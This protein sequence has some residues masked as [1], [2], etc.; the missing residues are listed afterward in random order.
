[1]NSLSKELQDS[2]TELLAD[3]KKAV[4]YNPRWWLTALKMIR[5]QRQAIQQRK[6]HLEVHGMHIPPMLIVSVTNRCNLTCKGCYNQKFHAST[7]Q[8]MSD[9]RL[10]A[11][12]QEAEVLGI[13]YVILVGG[14]PLSRPGLLNILS[15]FSKID[16]I[17]FTNGTLINAETVQIFRKQ[18]HIIPVISNEG[19]THHTDNRRGAGISD[20]ATLAAK[21]LIKNGLI[22]GSSIT[23]SRDNFSEVMTGAPIDKLIKTG[24][25]LFFLIEY[26]PVTEGSESLCLTESEC[27]ALRNRLLYF[28]NRYRS[29]FVGFPGDEERFGGCLAAGRGFLHINASGGVEACPFAPVSDISIENATLAQ[30]LQSPLMTTIRQNHA[31]LEESVGGCALWQKREWLSALAHQVQFKTNANQS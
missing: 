16:F 24:C 4:L 5:R 20:A 14:E 11:I 29:M 1:M 27:A 15:Q 28:R 31:E 10:I 26:V 23:V 7:S 30:A 19:G 22:F 3:I 18:R 25:S 21:A 6:M 2:F 8:E 12:F 9:D 17:L 13:S